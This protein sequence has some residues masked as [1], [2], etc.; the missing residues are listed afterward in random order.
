MTERERRCTRKRWRERQQESRMRHRV[1][2]TNTPPLTPDRD[3]EDEPTSQR[4]RGRKGKKR[5]D[6]ASYRIIIKLKE[7]LKAAKRDKERYRK[8]FERERSNCCQPAKAAL[9]SDRTT[10]RSK[11]QQMLSSCLVT[12]S[13]NK[14]LLFHNALIDDMSCTGRNVSTDADV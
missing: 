10:P 1:A 6:S 12:P 7:S 8:K 4:R 2:A 5:R 11:T 13:V 14:T 3:E 9:S